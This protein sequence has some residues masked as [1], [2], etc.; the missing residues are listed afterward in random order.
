MSYPE[1][2]SRS[3]RKVLAKIKASNAE[4]L[5]SDRSRCPWTVT[6]G[7]VDLPAFISDGKLYIQAPLPQVFEALAEN[8]SDFICDM[9]VRVSSAGGTTLSLDS[10]GRPLSGAAMAESSLVRD[11]EVRR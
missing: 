1:A 3:G 2:H 11:S 5:R 4:A 10:D 6:I 9:E 7:N 8:I